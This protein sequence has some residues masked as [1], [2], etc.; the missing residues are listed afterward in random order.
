M[1]K[2]LSTVV[3]GLCLVACGN[4]NEKANSNTNTVPTQE[5]SEGTPST[6][7]PNGQTSETNSTETSSTKDQ[8]TFAEFRDQFPKEFPPYSIA[9]DQ[10]APST[11]ALPG[12]VQLEHLKRS[13]GAIPVAEI[14]FDDDTYI[15][16]ITFETPLP[17]IAVYTLNMFDIGGEL[18]AHRVIAG[19][20]DGD[21]FHCKI[22]GEGTIEVEH[23]YPSGKDEMGE[24]LFGKKEMK[25][26]LQDGEILRE[27]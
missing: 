9:A 24:E 12:P 6:E 27:G 18:L 16:L 1:R 15:G 19:N 13:V 17:E 7:T 25:L 10:K 11:E 14:M 21:Q 3:L 26:V 5:V 23:Y 2:T 4:G 8:M 20:E 22:N